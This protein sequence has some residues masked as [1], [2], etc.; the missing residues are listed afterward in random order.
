[1][2]IFDRY[3]TFDKF[4]IKES[5]ILVC[6][7][8]SLLITFNITTNVSKKKKFDDIKFSN[9]I[10][11]YRKDNG[12][13]PLEYDNKVEYASQIQTKYNYSHKICEHYNSKFPTVKERLIRANV[14][15]P[16]CYSE[17]LI[18]IKNVKSMRNIE[19]KVLQSYINSK[20]HKRNM[21]LSCSKKIGVFTIY[22][23]K[24]LY[25]TVVFC[26]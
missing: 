22:D 11:E 13:K 18:V 16:S 3:N 9:L 20:S 25:S 5:F 17:N 10:N 2:K 15:N 6:I 14:N 26:D 4:H 21:L 23:G 12:L 24:D 7:F 8:L 1:M 19:E